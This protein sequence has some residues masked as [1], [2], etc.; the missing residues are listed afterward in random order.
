MRKGL[1]RNEDIHNITQKSIFL[2]YLPILLLLETLKIVSL[3]A[4]FIKSL[5]FQQRIKEKIH[6]SYTDK[7][8]CSKN[9]I[10]RFHECLSKAK[11][12]HPQRH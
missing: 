5:Q 8:K 12:I 6:Q 3:F 10:L 11:L 7:L 9:C 2:S 4:V 1:I